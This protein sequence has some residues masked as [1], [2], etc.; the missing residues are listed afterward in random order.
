[1]S[2]N[3]REK[4]LNLIRNEYRDAVDQ[5]NLLIIPTVE[6]FRKSGSH[7]LVIENVPEMENTL[8]PDPSVQWEFIS[9][10]DYIKKTIGLSFS[11]P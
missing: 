4:L 11:S 2:K 10:I 1:M 3:G 7:T 6:I 5:R 8:I 9:I